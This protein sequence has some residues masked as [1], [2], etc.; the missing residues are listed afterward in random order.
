MRR[1]KELLK[2][3]GFLKKNTFSKVR[4]HHYL[5]GVYGNAARKKVIKVLNGKK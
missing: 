2:N 4:D 3:V 5:T 1:V